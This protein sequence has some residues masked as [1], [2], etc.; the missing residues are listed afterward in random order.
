MGVVERRKREREERRAAILA[1]AEKVFLDKGVSAATMDEIASVAE[2]SKGTLYLY[3]KNKD[4]LFLAIAIRTLE[5]LAGVVENAATGASGLERVQSMLAALAEYAVANSDRF[6]VSTSWITSQYVVSSEGDRFDEYRA[7]IGRMFQ[8]GVTSILQGQRDGS[9]RDDL[10]APQL[11]IQ[12]WGAMT[13]T[14]LV[15]TRADELSRR[16]P[17]P[18][19]VDDLISGFLEL[20]L[21][22][23]R[24][25]A[26][27]EQSVVRARGTA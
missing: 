9:I 19:P 23:L 4:D 2:V 24:P 7:L 15:R 17:I 14:L 12:L 11:A 5:V 13:G 1:A 21:R 8:L 22:G 16:L 25:A 3:F 6:R 27:L 20:A 10:P 26:D 18:V